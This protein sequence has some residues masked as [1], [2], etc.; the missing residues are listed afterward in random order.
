MF[1][2]NRGTLKVA[3]VIKK[4]AKKRSLTEEPLIIN[5]SKSKRFLFDCVPKTIVLFIKLT[6]TIDFTLSRQ[7]KILGRGDGVWPDSLPSYGKGKS[8]DWNF[9]ILNKR[10]SKH[11]CISQLMGRFKLPGWASTACPLC[12][13]QVFITVLLSVKWPT[14][15]ATAEKRKY[16]VLERNNHDW[17]RDGPSISALAAAPPAHPSPTPHTFIFLRQKWQQLGLPREGRRGLGHETEI[18]VWGPAPTCGDGPKYF[19]ADYRE[20]AKA[21]SHPLPP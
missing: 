4:S 10:V 7:S 11:Q 6:D 13:M 17:E 9:K 5:I 21:H 18:Q 20:G 16:Q 2:P 12:L 1:E 19:R 3:Q 8:T 15:Q 14:H